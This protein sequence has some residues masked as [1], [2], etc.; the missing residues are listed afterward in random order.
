M[1][2]MLTMEHVLLYLFLQHNF[3]INGCKNTHTKKISIRRGIQRYKRQTL[4]D[5]VEEYNRSIP[6]VKK[7]IFE[8]EP[9]YKT[10][11]PRVI[12]LICM[13]HFMV[14]EKTY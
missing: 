6:W 3:F 8:Y 5:L 12:N 1:L 13:L 7:Q 4:Q 11:D 14:R 2:K 10:H 9:T